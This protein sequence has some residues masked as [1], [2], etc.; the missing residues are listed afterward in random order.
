MKAAPIP[1]TEL[2]LAQ[3]AQAWALRAQGHSWRATAQALHV[4]PMA[5][6]Q[7]LRG[8]SNTPPIAAA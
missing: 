6:R 1:Y 5:V 8:L 4:H 2:A 7:A 3:I